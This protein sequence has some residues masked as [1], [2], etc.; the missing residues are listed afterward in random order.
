[1][2]QNSPTG[3]RWVNVS[4]YVGT[5]IFL[6]ALTMSALIIPQLR[7]LHFFQAL[8]YIAIIALTRQ[9]RLSAWGFGIGV[10]IPVLWNTMNLFVTHLFQAGAGQLWSL[11]RTGLVTRPDTLL[12]FVGGVAHFLLI[13]A[14]MAG[15]LQLRPAKK[16]WLKF[17]GGG[18]LAFAYFVL[19]IATMA[20]R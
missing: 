12:V 18:L 16:H 10:F 5:A 7:L 11:L 6:L 2:D 19:I 13:V 8:I 17:F 15:F 3:S 1:M 14:C 9:N 20:P 4:I